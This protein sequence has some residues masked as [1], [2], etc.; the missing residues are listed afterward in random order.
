ILPS[1]G[2][3]IV[4]KPLVHKDFYYGCY[5]F[6]IYPTD[7][8]IDLIHKT[9]YAKRKRERFNPPRRPSS[10]CQS[11]PGAV[12]SRFFQRQSI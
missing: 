9:F 10:E 2:A 1:C 12:L 6:R 8:Q 7:E 11:G 3:I 4:I 5:K